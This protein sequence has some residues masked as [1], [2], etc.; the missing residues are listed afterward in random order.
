MFGTVGHDE[1]LNDKAIREGLVSHFMTKIEIDE[2]N[3]GMGEAYVIG[4]PT[5]KIL[6]TVLRAGSKLSVSSRADSTFKGRKDGLP[7][8]DEETYNLS[9]WDFVIDPGFLEANPNIAESINNEL[10]N[11]KGELEMEK[12]GIEKTLVEHIA[13]ENSDLKIN[14]KTLVDEVEA[15]KE[16]K[17]TLEEEN[18]QV[19]EELG[20]LEESE[21]SLNE[22]KEIG[23]VEEIKETKTK[24]EDSEKVVEAYSEMCDSPEHTKTIME[25]AH[26]FIKTIKEE[27]GSIDKIKEGLEEGSK[28]K[29]SVDELGGFEKVKEALERFDKTLSENEEKE[30]ASKTKE[31]AKELGLKEEKVT[32]LL[33]KYS[34]EDI[35]ELYKTV[36]ESND[37]SRFVKNSFNEN[38]DNNDD[39]SSE[40]YESKILG[41]NRTERIA[42]KL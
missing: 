15:L 35:K 38:N 26:D 37:G 18:K 13:N 10:E 24:L 29:E 3:K 39:D 14:V 20:K 42:S 7:I 9:G 33:A 36:S 41:S 1:E 11:I 17:I 34:F 23:T 4:T 30:L 32:E 28:L 16:D 6:N 25:K 19:K 2:S 31:L 40:L 27:F 8:V 12:T 22:Y 21:K 5:G